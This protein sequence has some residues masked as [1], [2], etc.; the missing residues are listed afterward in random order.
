MTDTFA[1]N[2]LYSK[3]KRVGADRRSERKRKTNA[4]VNCIRQGM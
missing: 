3:A 4:A 2:R 1:E